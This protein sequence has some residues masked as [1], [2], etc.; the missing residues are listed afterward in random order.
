[1]VRDH[2]APIALLATATGYLDGHPMFPKEAT[3][4]M[5]LKANTW[6]DPGCAEDGNPQLSQPVCIP[7]GPQPQPA[8][9]PLSCLG[10]IFCQMTLSQIQATIKECAQ[11]EFAR[12]RHTC[13]LS[14]YRTQH[15]AKDQRPTVSLDFNHIFTSI[16]MR[17][18]HEGD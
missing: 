10:A 12:I 14:Q 6:T 13:P 1:M 2:G 16:G 7:P 4:A 11:S 8:P 18:P 5:Y 9:S 15:T 3:F 17:S